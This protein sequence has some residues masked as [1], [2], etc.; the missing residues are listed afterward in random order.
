[1]QGYRARGLDRDATRVE[2]EAPRFGRVRRRRPPGLVEGG[3]DSGGS[4]GTAPLDCR[5]L[6]RRRFD[7]VGH[8]RVRVAGVSVAGVE[9]S[10]L[11]RVHVVGT[12][13][14]DEF[15]RLPV[16]DGDRD[17][18]RASRRRVDAGRY[19]KTAGS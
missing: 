18:R 1:M 2:N 9:P 19:G 3:G 15:G 10:D 4:L 7:E 17:G 14:L 11:D 13:R 8:G 6:R 16:V 12:D 5:Q